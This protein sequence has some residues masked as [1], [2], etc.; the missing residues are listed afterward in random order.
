MQ[1]KDVMFYMESPT[2]RVDWELYV[3]KLG[4][5]G[6]IVMRRRRGNSVRQ[7]K[8]CGQVESCLIV[9]NICGDFLCLKNLCTLLRLNNFTSFETFLA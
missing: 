9:V 8:S 7:L 1:F 5:P 6:C 4:V 2:G 3:G